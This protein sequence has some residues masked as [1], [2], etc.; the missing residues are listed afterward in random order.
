MSLN[1]FIYVFILSYYCKILG[2]KTSDAYLFVRLIAQKVETFPLE[3]VKDCSQLAL[4]DLAVSLIINSLPPVA[5]LGRALSAVIIRLKPLNNILLCTKLKKTFTQTTSLKK[6]DFASFVLHAACTSASVRR[7]VTVSLLSSLLAAL[8]TINR[9]S[10][11]VTSQVTRDECKHENERDEDLKENSQE[12]KVKESKTGTLLSLHVPHVRNVKADFDEEL[13]TIFITAEENVDDGD[14]I[15]GD[16]DKMTTKLEK[17][18]FQYD[19]EKPNMLIG[20]KVKVTWS[21]MEI[22]EAK[23]TNYMTAGVNKG[24]HKV[25]YDDGDIRFYK[26]QLE[27]NTKELYAFNHDKLND[28]HKISI[29][30]WSSSVV[31]AAEPLKVGKRNFEIKLNDFIE[32]SIKCDD[33]K[34][35]YRKDSGIL[36]LE[37]QG[38]RKR[39]AKK[40]ENVANKK[41]EQ[42]EMMTM[43]RFWAAA[44]RRRCIRR[45]KRLG[46]IL[47]Y[48]HYQYQHIMSSYLML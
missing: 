37:L 4:V 32:N 12:I 14:N 45:N 5:S 38:A 26:I 2:M 43:V 10:Q 30:E 22:F 35:E 6:V 40:L 16:N 13:N 44:T 25:L 41:E 27:S 29:M 42:S 11:N 21:R 46:T 31:V 47:R 20:A 7:T 48:H 24:K 34:F 9:L 15:N 3:M 18:K 17:V 36:V 33:V 23:I 19:P 1:I 39:I 8:T 28:K